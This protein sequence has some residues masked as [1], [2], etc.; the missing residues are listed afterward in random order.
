MAADL[1]HLERRLD[2]LTTALLLPLRAEKVLDPV[3]MADLSAL[4][5]EF[6]PR[7]VSRGRR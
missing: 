6:V 3:L 7:G 2:E 5:D 4:M 1:S